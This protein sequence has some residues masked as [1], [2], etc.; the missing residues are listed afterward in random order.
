[1]LGGLIFYAY[2]FVNDGFVD[3]KKKIVLSKAEI[4]QFTN[5]WQRKFFRKPTPTEKQALVDKAI[6]T[7]IMY[8]EALKLGLDKGDTIIRRR[9][10][11]K[12]EFLSENF[13]TQTSV[14]QKSLQE[15]MQKN[16]K[17]FLTPATISL[18]FKDSIVPQNEYTDIRQWKLSRVFGRD[19]AKKIF[20]LKVGVLHENIASIY[21]NVSFVIEKKT[22]ASLPK[23]AEIEQRVKEAF[24]AKRKIALEHKFYENLKSEYSIEIGK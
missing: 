2:S 1:M 21:G 12:L 5:I 15:F 6:Y 20:S 13:T 4:E 16:P 7:E 10:V 8:R 18:T 24:L 17:E 11:Q 3:E 23:L 19:F 9:L 14:T 22:E